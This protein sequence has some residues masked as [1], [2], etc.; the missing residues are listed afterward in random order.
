MGRK[1]RST[2][3]VIHTELKPK[4]PNEDELREKEERS[5]EKQKSNYDLRHNAKPQVPLLPDMEVHVKDM[6]TPGFVVSKAQ[7]PRS[8][9]VETPS[10]IIRRNRSQLL[11]MPAEVEDTVPLPVVEADQAKNK[12]RTPAKPPPSPCLSTRPR[13]TIKP[14]LK[15]RENLGLT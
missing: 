15:V 1:L 6:N 13:R 5:R 4:L 12:V 3:P 2:V 10:N 9:F 11:P 14:S 7:S 8:Y